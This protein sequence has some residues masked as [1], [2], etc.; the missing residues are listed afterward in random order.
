M[1][2][3]LCFLVLLLVSGIATGQQS[4][5]ASPSPKARSLQPPAPT[6]S[7]TR[8]SQSPAAAGSSSSQ[9]APQKPA[10]SPAS[11]SASQLQATRPS[12]PRPTLL[13]AYWPP[14]TASGGG[15]EQPK[16]FLD[17]IAIIDGTHL[18][19]PWARTSDTPGAINKWIPH[20]GRTFFPKGRQYD[21]YEGGQ[22]VD[23]ATVVHPEP[24]N[25]DGLSAVVKLV[26]PGP[27][28]AR[29]AL[30]GG[31]PHDLHTDWR[32][33]AT[34]EQKV[35]F[36]QLAQNALAPAGVAANTVRV[37]NLAVTRLDEHQPQ[38][39]VGD[40]ASG[41][42][43]V[44][45]IAEP[46]PSTRGAY[47]QAFASVHNVDPEDPNTEQSEEFLDQ[48]DVTNDG[49]DEVVTIVY[50]DQSWTYNIYRR[51]PKGAWE[52]IYNGGGGG[53]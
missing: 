35:A 34:P 49:V 39:L 38:L 40:A 44:F 11:K 50:L 19:D 4:P 46:D 33:P 22:K 3:G 7:Q 31:R 28:P 12:P 26:A 29:K 1:R 36:L 32:H 27:A 14:E 45:L 51:T 47:K 15:P 5:S 23:T 17:T 9:A 8:T 53:C 48:L 10:S 42:H 43:H 41:T 20:F 30:G 25:C 37:L 13:L 16:A 21:I 52:N 6:P 24:I 18:I 2:I